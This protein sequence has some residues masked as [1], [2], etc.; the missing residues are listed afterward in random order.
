M[1]RISRR[2]F[3]LKSGRGIAGAALAPMALSAVNPAHVRGG[4]PSAIDRVNMA[5][6]GC[7]G[8]GRMVIR[9]MAESGARITFLCDLH[10]GQLAKAARTVS[11]VQ[12]TAPRLAND[13]R[14]VL[15][16]KEVDAV[17]IGTPDHWHALATILA[18]Q[19]GKDVYVEKPHSH[20]IWEA[21]RMI[22]AARKYKR[23]VQVGTQCRSAPYTMAGREY[24]KSGKL[25]G[26]HLV[27][28][29]NIKPGRPFYLGEAGSAPAGFDWD[30]WLGGAPFRPYHQNIFEV[31]WHK[32]WDFSGGDMADDG[33]HQ[34]DLA[35]MLMGNPPVPTAASCSG[36]RLQHAGD[37][38]EVP[39]VQIVTYDFKDFVM[40]FELT[41]Y[42]RYMR[43]TTGTIRR[44]DKF[45]Y[46]TQNATRIELYGSELM[47]TV[48]R[49]GGGWQVTTSGG[50]VVDQ[51]YGRFPDAPHFQNFIECVRSR[52]R[53][54]ADIESIQPS[55]TMVH[56]G[57]IAHRVGNVKLW[58]DAK[59]EQFI[60]NEAANKLVKRRYRK[61]YE[62]PEQV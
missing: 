36:G 35:M 48:G 9:S 45:P 12:D 42:P 40:T 27:K 22:E 59:T 31:G 37:D 49:H 15:D 14:Q 61:K 19:A 57:N 34:I 23:V 44:S 6:I 32:F 41:G 51:M 20:S 56:I 16:S 29:Y 53:P 1:E 54:N 18:C 4:D 38:A 2:H 24:V 46:W 58:F 26:I 3:L 21:R 47:M 62:V 43:K 33:I 52:K 50:K 30:A 11:E 7:G 39:D 17:V 60:G 5:L 8:R 28:V 10:P 13:M 55:M 25:G